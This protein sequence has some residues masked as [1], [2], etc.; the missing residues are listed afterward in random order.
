VFRSPRRRCDGARSFPRLEL[1]EL[2]VMPTV[3]FDLGRQSEPY[4]LAPTLD[5][6]LGHTPAPGLLAARQKGFVGVGHSRPADYDPR[7]ACKKLQSLSLAHKTT[8]VL[9]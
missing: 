2:A 1:A 9:R 3:D 5:A 7:A 8:P 4:V 6:A